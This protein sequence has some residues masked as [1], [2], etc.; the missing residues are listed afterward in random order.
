MAKKFFDIEERPRE[1][2][3]ENCVS[4]YL[5]GKALGWHQMYMKI[6][7]RNEWLR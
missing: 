1:L 3:V 6:R 2:K 4:I 5:E 7:L